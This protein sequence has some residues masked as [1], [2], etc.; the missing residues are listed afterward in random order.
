MHH[1]SAWKYRTVF[2]GV[3]IGHDE[4]T[5]KVHTCEDTSTI[6]KLY[7]YAVCDS[8]VRCASWVPPSLPATF[9]SGDWSLNNFY[10]HSVSSADSGRTGYWLVWGLGKLH[11]YSQNHTQQTHQTA[12]RFLPDTVSFI[13]RSWNRRLHN[14]RLN[15]AYLDIYLNITLVYS[16]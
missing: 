15:K 8:S 16:S 13:A 3:W 6:D 11:W 1:N 7:A 12:H 14:R 10:G 4:I 5:L 2:P 9:F